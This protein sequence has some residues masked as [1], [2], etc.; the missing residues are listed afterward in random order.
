MLRVALELNLHL[1]RLCSQGFV[2]NEVILKLP[3][4]QLPNY[5]ISLVKG[6]FGF[7]KH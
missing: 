4:Y 6:Y 2:R 7:L 3:T 5:Q 1:V